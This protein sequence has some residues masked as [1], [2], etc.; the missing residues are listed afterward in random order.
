MLP[1]ESSVTPGIS[2]LPRT[3][4]PMPEKNSKSPTRFACGNAP[5]GSG[6]RELSIA[7][8]I[9]PF[10]TADYADE[11][12]FSLACCRFLSRSWERFP[13]RRIVRTNFFHGVVFQLRSHR[14]GLNTCPSC[15]H[16]ETRGDNVRRVTKRC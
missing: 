10:V 11:N 12:G 3:R 16:A 9:D 8:L 15:S 7:S 4:G 2:L 14:C 6:A 13:T 1:D 5:T